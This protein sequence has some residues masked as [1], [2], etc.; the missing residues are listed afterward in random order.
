MNI[1]RLALSANCYWAGQYP[2]YTITPVK[3]PSSK[4]QHELLFRH[5]KCVSIREP[6]DCT[7]HPCYVS[8]L[9]FEQLPEGN[10]QFAMGSSIWVE[11]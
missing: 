10:F 6:Y 1:Q 8:L 4:P 3:N 7:D 5:V 9:E 2:T 11:L